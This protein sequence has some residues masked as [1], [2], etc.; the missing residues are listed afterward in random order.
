MNPL[1]A[2]E[3]WLRQN[4]LPGL[5]RSVETNWSRQVRDVRLFEVGTVYR[6]GGGDGR[7]EETMRVA[8]VITGARSP[9]HWTDG[10]RAPDVDL[11][12][13]KSLFEAAVALAIPGATVQVEASRWIATL[14]GRRVGRAERQGITPPAWAA[15]LFGFELE[16][17]AAP[18]PAV[19]FVPSPVT[20]AA[21]RDVNLLVPAAVGAAGVIAAMRKSAGKLLEAVDVVSEF[22]APEFGEDR[23]A[24]QFRLVIRAEDRTVRDEEVDALI[25][26]VLKTVEKELDARLRTS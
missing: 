9:A 7:P 17:S 24:V 25:A 19:R 4:L 21:W 5:T 26:R 22:R 16:L 13:L 18:R 10:G 2:E 23:R 15:P 8:A 20:P 14:D 1:S 3:A 11:W 6:Q 12:D